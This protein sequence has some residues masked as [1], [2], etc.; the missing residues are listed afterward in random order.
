MREEQ[1]GLA[2]RK[3]LPGCLAYHRLSKVGWLVDWELGPG[4]R[5]RV[6]QDPHLDQGASHD[7]SIY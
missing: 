2:L 4:R 1:K 3:N 5:E 6:P 7:V